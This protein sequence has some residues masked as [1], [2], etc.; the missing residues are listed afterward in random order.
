M[1]WKTDN[2]SYLRTL[3]YTK[4]AQDEKSEIKLKLILKQNKTCPGCGHKFDFDDTYALLQIFHRCHIHSHKCEKYSKEENRLIFYAC[5]KCN[6]KQTKI[7]GYWTK[8]F[9][10]QTLCSKDMYIRIF[11]NELEFIDNLI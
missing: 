3:K 4:I 2:T 11:P 1:Y 5:S 9:H 7:C 8:P 6:R 10:L